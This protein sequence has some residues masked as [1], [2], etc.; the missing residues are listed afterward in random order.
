M[1]YISSQEPQII[2]GTLGQ[3]VLFHVFVKSVV[4]GWLYDIPGQKR[5]DSIG[6]YMWQLYVKMLECSVCICYGEQGGTMIYYKVCDV[7]ILPT[8]PHNCK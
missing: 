8:L 6:N 2:D 3:I 4:T 7:V 1:I 5:Q